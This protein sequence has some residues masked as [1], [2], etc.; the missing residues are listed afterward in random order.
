MC[1]VL[2]VLIYCIFDD[3]QRDGHFQ[4]KVT[5]VYFSSIN[6]REGQWGVQNS[7]ER[8]L[9]MHYSTYLECLND[10]EEV[11]VLCDDAST[12]FITLLYDVSRAPALLSGCCCNCA[13]HHA[14]GL[15]E[16]DALTPLHFD[17]SVNESH[18]T[19]LCA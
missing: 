18:S 6:E 14:T 13:S 5:A 11:C 9:K 19:P 4:K 15:I 16:P 12:M 7:K 10:H 2:T 17:E 3:T 1:C 8:V